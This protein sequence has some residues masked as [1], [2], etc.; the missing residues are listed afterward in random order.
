M[1]SKQRKSPQPVHKPRR[2]STPKHKD[3]EEIT[4]ELREQWAVDADRSAIEDFFG[5]TSSHFRE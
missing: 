4:K 3:S 1:P 5:P 2:P